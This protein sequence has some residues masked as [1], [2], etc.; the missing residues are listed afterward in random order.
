MKYL[1]ILSI[2]L[3]S[4]LAQAET[5]NV[6]TGDVSRTFGLIQTSSKF[7]MNTTTTQGY[8]DV[9]VDEITYD[10]TDIGH[11]VC[12]Q[13]GCHTNGS[14][15]IPTIYNLIQTRVLVE[16]LKLVGKEMI[17]LGE[18]GEVKCGN[19]GTSRV[20]RRPTLYLTGNCILRE[21]I[22]GNQVTVTLQIK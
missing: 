21:R 11:T 14:T 15:P 18:N 19:L 7:F 22:Q 16:N 6:F 13:F 8:V 10:H 5:I 2:L 12:N 4:F 1:L 20:L 9:S 17:Y 3:F